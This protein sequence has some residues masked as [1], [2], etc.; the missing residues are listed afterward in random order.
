VDAPG[1]AGGGTDKAKALVPRL[2]Q[3]SAVRAHR[4]RGMIYA[5]D[6]TDS[7]ALEEYNAALA[8][9]H[10]PEAYVDLA[11]FYKSRKQMEK[12]AENAKLA[13]QQDKKH[14]PDTLDAAAILI[15]LKTDPTVVQTALRAYLA[16][17]QSGVARYAKAHVLLGTSLQVSGDSAGAQREFSAAQAL[18][19]RYE[20]A[21]KASHG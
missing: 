2:A 10:E 8:A 12:A 13:I 11:I 16:S 3:V 9:T 1:V 17:P 4:L 15:D 20:A 14:G 19:S 7:A 21:R 18:A 5:K 6:K